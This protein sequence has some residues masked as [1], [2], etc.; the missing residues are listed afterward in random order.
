[1]YPKFRKIKKKIK[2][3]TIRGFFSIFPWSDG[4]HFPLP[5]LG[6]LVFRDL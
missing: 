4:S 1:M 3:A 2:N 6:F 5:S